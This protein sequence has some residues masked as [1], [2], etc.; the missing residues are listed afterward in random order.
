[1]WSMFVPGTTSR[2]PCRWKAYIWRGIARYPEGV[3]CDSTITGSCRLRWCLTPWLWWP[4]VLLVV[5][6]YYRL[7]SRGRL[8]LDFGRSNNWVTARGR[9]PPQTLIKWSRTCA[10]MGLIAGPIF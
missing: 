9:F 1:L 4:T 7:P 3:V 8:G 2:V 5:L 10:T 6:E